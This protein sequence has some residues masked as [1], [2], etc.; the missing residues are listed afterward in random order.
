VAAPLKDSFGPDVAVRIAGMLADVHPTFPT[1]AFL[2][3]ALDGYDDLELTP[4]ARQIAVA[5]GAH[6]PQDFDEA[7]TIVVASLGPPIDGD[8][9]TGVGMEP[10]VYLPHVFWVAERGPDHWETSMAAQ[11]QLTQRFTCEY[12]IRAFI[13]REPERTLARLREWTADLNPHV[14]RLVSEGTRPRLPWAPRLQRFVKDPAPVI[15]LLELLRDDPTTLVRRSV[16][17]NLNDVGKDHPDLL[18]E[19]CRHWSVG[20]SPERW[21]LIRHAL[22]SAVKRGD[23]GALELLGF[24]SAGSAAVSDVKIS[25]ARPAIGGTVEVRCTVTNRDQETAAFNV[26]LRVHFVKAN[27]SVSPKV[28]KVKVVELSPG[29]STELAKSISLAQHSTRT[30]YPGKHAVELVVNGVI[31]P[32]GSFTVRGRSRRPSR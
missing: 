18:I 27:G 11:Y 19:V 6:L 29:A 21:H 5:M 22:R 24:G 12:S 8:E 4:R 14:R 31:E 2:R 1:D 3:D 23:A 16:A 30:H 32:I 17:N 10:F 25:P 28:F 9:L 15:Q 26:D 7:A 13:D 20:A